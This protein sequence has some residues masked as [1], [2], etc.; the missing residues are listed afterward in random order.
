MVTAY[1]PPID[2]ILA[3][4]KLFGGLNATSEIPEIAHA[5]ESTVGELLGEFGRW[6]AEEVAPL[7]VVGD[8]N[9]A[10]CDSVAKTVTT[11]PGF[12]DAYH[13]FVDAGWPSVPFDPE[14]GGGGFP[15]AVAIAMNE[16]LGAANLAFSLCPLLGQGAIDAISHH[17]NVS[18]KEMYL[19]KLISGEW[20]GTMNLTEPEAGSD[21][22]ALRTRAVQAADGTWRIFGQKI[23]ITYGEHDMAD[24][25]VHLVLA[26]IDGAAP[27]TKGI[28]CFLVPK[29]AVNADG[30]LGDR[31][32]AY[33]VSIE[34]KLGIHG[35]PTCV[36]VY[37]DDGIGAIGELLGEPNDGM[38]TMFTMMNNAR[39][40]VGTQGLS[41]ADRAS[42]MAHTYAAERV[43]GRVIGGAPGAVSPISQHPD[44]QRMLLTMRANIGA[45]RA[46]IYTN[47]YA[48]DVAR[49]HPDPDM[50]DSA[51]KTAE[52]LTPLSKSFCTD[53][54]VEM[55]SMAL[56]VFGGMG[57]VEETGVAQLY[58]DIRIAPIYE[59]TNAIQAIDLVTRKIT[60][61]GGE[62]V[63]RVLDNAESAATAANSRGLTH[64]IGAAREVTNYMQERLSTNVAD[65]LAGATPY[66]R[67]LAT[68]IAGGFMAQQLAVPV[69][70]AAGQARNHAA[71]FFCEQIAPAT[72]GLMAAAMAGADALVR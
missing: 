50:R 27:G 9:P 31:N 4:L 39:L 40:S 26:R 34:H 29:F 20:T 68:A 33:V 46:L 19:A 56:Q 21:V 69:T 32:D 11:P 43:Q 28:S 22:G 45:M 5:D 67:M 55:T 17:G 47:A 14:F 16:I 2:D 6:V 30:S 71:E 72:L 24:N 15:W 54:G 53:L 57:F 8:R 3:A 12:K 59:G 60:I 65:V 1:Q 61:D 41:L 70:D 38:R 63:H 25:I 37:G 48:L 18:Q 7:N 64:A 58:R 23:F 66:L 42:Q 35:S 10:T 36:M 13:Q 49:A 52:L 62:F 51:R 44:V